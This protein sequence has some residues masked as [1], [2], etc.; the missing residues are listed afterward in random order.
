MSLLDTLQSLNDQF[1]A[2]CGSAYEINNGYCEEWAD[3]AFGLL[4]D[5]ADKVEVWATPY[6]FAD[7]SHSF[8][9]V[10]GK[11][12]DAECLTGVEDHND[13][14]IFKKLGKPQ[15]VW[16]ENANHNEAGDTTRN[17]SPEL[18]KDIREEQ[19]DSGVDPAQALSLS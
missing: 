10:D 14:P 19:I 13:L 9:R 7:T 15:P 4:H 17:I 12:Y 11:F 5:K 3:Q 6:F 8:I 1:I 18:R 16:M 2:H